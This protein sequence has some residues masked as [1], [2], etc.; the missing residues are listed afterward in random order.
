MNTDSIHSIQL[1]QLLDWS[2]IALVPFSVEMNQWHLL[3]ACPSF[4]IHLLMTNHLTILFSCLFRFLLTDAVIAS[5]W[6]QTN[7]WHCPA[8]IAL[9]GARGE[10]IFSTIEPSNTDNFP[11]LTSLEILSSVWTRF[12]TF[13]HNIDSINIRVYRS[14][15]QFPSDSIHFECIKLTVWKGFKF[16][17]RQMWLDN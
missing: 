7:R 13:S 11:V 12:A 6:D 4:A 1:I 17:A 9:I 16:H 2:L 3:V 14:A 8:R 5:E 15:F 10:L